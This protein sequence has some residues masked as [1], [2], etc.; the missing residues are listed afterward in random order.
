MNTTKTISHSAFFLLTLSLFAV[1]L[2]ACQPQA[3][4]IDPDAAMTQAVQTAFAAI[5]QTK[6]LHP[7]HQDPTPNTDLPQTPPALPAQFHNHR[8]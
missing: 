6:A 1:L 8:P 2:N 3:P 5:Q 7:L 4:T